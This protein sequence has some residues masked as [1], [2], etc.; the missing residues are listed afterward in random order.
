MNRIMVLTE[1]THAKKMIRAVLENPECEILE[2]HDAAHALELLRGQTITCMLVDCSLTGVQREM[3]HLLQ[4]SAGMVSVPVVWI[5]NY[6]G[7]DPL[8]REL[9]LTPLNVLH[10]PFTPLQL[11]EKM[12]YSLWLGPGATTLPYPAVFKSA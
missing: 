11:L 8:L 9:Q 6:G 7:R 4:Y 2:P 10:K 5:S 12:Q 3:L 1:D